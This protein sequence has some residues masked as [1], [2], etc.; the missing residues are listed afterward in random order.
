MVICVTWILIDH[1]FFR[2]N[3]LVSDKYSKWT[4]PLLM[5]NQLT[6][7]SCFEAVVSRDFIL[8]N[9]E[10]ETSSVSCQKQRNLWH[11]FIS[12]FSMSLYITYIKK[13]SACGS[14]GHIFRLFCGSVGQQVWPTFNPAAYY[15]LITHVSKIMKIRHIVLWYWIVCCR[16]HCTYIEDWLMGD[17]SKYHK[18]A[19]GLN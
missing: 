2:K 9:S 5:W 11:C 18:I 8:K 16:Y 13:A 7:L 6:T 15:F 10:H 19:S 3:T 4:E 17:E 12:D 1:M 14:V